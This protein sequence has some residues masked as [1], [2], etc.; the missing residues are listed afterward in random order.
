M[1][2]KEFQ[3][4]CCVRNI[5]LKDSYNGKVYTR[6]DK[7]QDKQVTGFYPRFDM[8]RSNN[9][10]SPMACLQIVAWIDHDFERENYEL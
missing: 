5:V 4:F 6:L 3:E 10:Y 1:T 8:M 2:V 7:Y 9:S